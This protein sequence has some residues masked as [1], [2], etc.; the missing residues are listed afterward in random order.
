MICLTHNASLHNLMYM[1]VIFRYL[2][3]IFESK[4]KN[5]FILDNLIMSADACGLLGTLLPF[6]KL[7]QRVASQPFL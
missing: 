4:E 5:F 1:L 7:F 6:P 2:S 3:I